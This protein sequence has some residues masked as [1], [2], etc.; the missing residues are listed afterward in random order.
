MNAQSIK[1]RLLHKDNREEEGFYPENQLE[2]LRKIE[3]K[4]RDFLHEPVFKDLLMPVLFG[5]DESNRL[6]VLSAK[7]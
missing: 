4:V 2:S 6:K 5:C 1:D 3:G 7:P